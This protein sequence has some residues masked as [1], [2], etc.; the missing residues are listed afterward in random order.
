MRFPDSSF[1]ACHSEVGNKSVD[2]IFQPGVRM[3][4]RKE[5]WANGAGF[6]SVGLPEALEA[7]A[8][9]PL[10]SGCVLCGSC[11][12]HLTLAPFLFP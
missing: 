1:I 5:C 7:A 4:F 10:P 3:G 11:D 6:V 12:V 2:H 9:G 8:P